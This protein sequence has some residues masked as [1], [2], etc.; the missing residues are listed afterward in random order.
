MTE[1]QAVM[2]GK[3]DPRASMVNP[4]KSQAEHLSVCSHPVPTTGFTEKLTPVCTLCCPGCGN[5]FCGG[6]LAARQSGEGLLEA[7]LWGAVAAS[8][9]AECWAVPAC[10]PSAKHAEA[11]QRVE[12]LRLRCRPLQGLLSRR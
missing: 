10:P 11:V 9:M 4:S 6:F 5:A 7:G 12:S 1:C 8:F 3:L 2:L